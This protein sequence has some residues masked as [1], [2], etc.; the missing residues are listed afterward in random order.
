MDGKKCQLVRKRVYNLAKQKNSAIFDKIVILCIV[1]KQCKTYKDNDDF[2][3][4]TLVDIYDGDIHSPSPLRLGYYQES[5][6]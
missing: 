5:H 4:N 3:N 6:V 2:K 1:V